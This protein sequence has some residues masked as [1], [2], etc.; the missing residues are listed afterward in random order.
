MT[1]WMLESEK[2]LI[3]G[4]T[5]KIGFPIA[6]SLAECNEV[7]GAA[8]LRDPADRQKLA[9]GGVTPVPLDMS[10]GDYS[11]LPDDFTYVFHAAVDVGAGGGQ[12]GGGTN[13]EQRWGL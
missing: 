11:A 3:T 7:W 6:R 10:T 12:G 2:V 4:V 1:S 9:A 5:G 13:P 8:R